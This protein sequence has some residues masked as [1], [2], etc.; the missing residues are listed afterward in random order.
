MEND[1]KICTVVQGKDLETFLKNL[2]KAQ[3][4]ASMV[5]LRADSIKDFNFDDLAI[6][7]GDIKV[8]SIFTF[9]HKKEG[10][11][12]KGALSK[13][14]EILKE[15]FELDFTYADVAHSNSLIHKLTSKNK[16][17]LILSY[18]NNKETPYL[19]DLVDLLNEIR[20]LRPAI[21]KIATFVADYDDILILTSLL[22]K[23]K[24]NE[25][26]IVIGM[27]KRGE[28]TRRTFP[29]MG[30]H[31]AY[32]TMKGEKD[33]APGMLTEKDLKPIIKYFNK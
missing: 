10:G 31:I 24:K 4:Y 8:P 3:T 1:F 26:L 18:H 33:I 2:K 20:K 23:K 16:K 19:E 22:K 28:I 15:A 13:Q 17:K 27:G 30:S 6:I 25:K 5:E 12:F 7:R 29:P 32:V 14:E 9:R 11:L 21:I